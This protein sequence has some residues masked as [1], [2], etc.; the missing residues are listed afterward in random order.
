M[1]FRQKP[2]DF[3]LFFL[4]CSFSLRA[5]TTFVL[6]TGDDVLLAKNLDWPVGDGFIVVNRRGVEKRALAMDGEETIVWKSIH[7]SVTFNQFGKE[8]PLGG[9]NEKGLV[10]EEMNYSLSQYPSDRQSFLNEFQWIQYHLDISESVK[11][12]IDSLH[13]ISILPLLFR[14]HYMV[15]D[16]RGQVAI[17]EFIG[18]KAKVYVGDQIEVPV[19]TN[20]CYDNLLQYLRGCKG[21]GGERMV[22]DGPE[23]QE[24]FV[25]A[26]TMI[27]NSC[28]SLHESVI[29]AKAFDILDH[30]K[31]NDTQWSIVYNSRKRQIRF[32]TRLVPQVRLV[33]LWDIDFENSDFIHILTPQVSGDYEQIFKKYSVEENTRLLK[34]VFGQLIRKGEISKESAATIVGRLVEFS[35]LGAKGD[36]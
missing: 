12:V 30:V 8:F 28:N 5:C 19:L 20:N 18:R 27:K 10:I 29:E 24:R 11:D 4:I 2:T 7:G 35:L 32:T 22:T 33:S 17:I 16:S 1:T 14:L 34:A 3:I 36:G 13:E 23:S 25:R 21:F 9:M 6:K 26:A 31:Q 15:C